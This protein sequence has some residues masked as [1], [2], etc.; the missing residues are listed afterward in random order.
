MDAQ[1]LQRLKDLAQAALPEPGEMVWF[2]TYQ[3]SSLD[4]ADAEF[5]C[6]V[7]P[8]A[9]LELIA[10]AERAVSP[11]ESVQKIE[12]DKGFA[13][14]LNAYND[15]RKDRSRTNVSRE[16]D[17]L[18]AYIDASRAAAHAE[19]IKQERKEADECCR[20]QAQQII[21]LRQRAEEAHAEGRRSAMEE[22]HPQWLKE[23]ERADKAEAELQEWYKL[24]N[25][26]SLHANLLRGIPARLTTG[27]LLHIAGDEAQPLQQEGGKEAPSQEWLS[28]L[29]Y[30][31]RRID[32]FRLRMSYN[33]SYFGEPAGL[34]K[35]CV[36][37]IAHMFDGYHR[38]ATPH[39]SDN[40]QQASTAQAEPWADFEVEPTGDAHYDAGNFLL[41]AAQEFWNACRQ[42]GQYG[43]VQW[44]T[45]G[46]GE[47]LIYT[48]GEYRETLMNNIW[49]IPGQEV[50]HF[51]QATPEGADLPPSNSAVEVLKW[52]A[53][54]MVRFKIYQPGIAELVR[55]AAEALAATTAAEPV[56]QVASIKYP[57]AWEDASVTHWKLSRDEGRQTR[58][59]YR[60]AP[61]QQVGT[62][63]LLG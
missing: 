1:E 6:T 41:N 16:F 37:E 24:K 18:V 11:A 48:R 56:Y 17:A 3:F 31:F 46:N 62:G 21:E 44:L 2:Q 12:D 54:D 15:A 9:V 47:L 5:I 53:D 59:L 20:H 55:K 13:D 58:T 7:S 33:D 38:G 63:G 45:G 40:L 60:A 35:G 39:P 57:G 61:P 51:V 26:V 42:A 49:K 19:G 8:A 4:K 52:L 10:L 25:P 29:E 27:Q 23:K 34:L 50:K 30:I 28:K 22:L 43:A 36:A 32:H 14:V